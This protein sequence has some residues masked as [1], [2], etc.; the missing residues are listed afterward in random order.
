VVLPKFEYLD[1]SVSELLIDPNPASPI[2]RE[3]RF[4]PE[5]TTDPDS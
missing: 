2:I 4:M 3:E 5:M 1:P